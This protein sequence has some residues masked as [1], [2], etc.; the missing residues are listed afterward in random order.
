[1]A[2]ITSVTEPGVVTAAITG[3]TT[4]PGVVATAISV[5]E[6]EQ[7]VVV[8]VIFCGITEPDYVTVAIP[9]GITEMPVDASVIPSGVRK[10]DLV[11]MV[12]DSGIIEHGFIT[13]DGG[14]VL[15]VVTME[16]TCDINQPGFLATEITSGVVTTLDTSGITKLGF[17]WV[18]NTGGE[19]FCHCVGH[20]IGVPP[21]QALPPRITASIAEPG[22]AS[23]FITVGVTGPDVCLTL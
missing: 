8:T 6:R 15:G 22:F 20:R 17:D 9:G 13:A 11:T 14:I 7:D 12:I 5:G 10:Q 23:A 4:E 18:K 21:S 2:A 19:R 16:I 1:M 3:G